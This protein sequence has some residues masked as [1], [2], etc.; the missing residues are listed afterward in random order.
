MVERQRQLAE[1]GHTV[2]DGRDIGTHVLPD[3]KVKVF[4]TA[5][6]DIR[7]KRRHEELLRKGYPSNL[8]ELKREIANRDELDSTRAFAPLCKA[9]GAKEIDTSSLSIDEVVT[10]IIDL[11]EE[12]I[13]I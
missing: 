2:L 6:V 8:E 12:S 11:V 1:K 4:L 7:A 5:S 9:K 3:A 13:L 10:A